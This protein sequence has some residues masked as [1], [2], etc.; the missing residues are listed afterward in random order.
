MSVCAV[1]PLYARPAE[2]TIYELCYGSATI[3][4]CAYRNIHIRKPE[5]H[6]C[7]ASDILH[8]L[9]RIDLVRSSE[10]R[11]QC[12]TLTISV[13][14]NPVWRSTLQRRHAKSGGYK[15]FWEATD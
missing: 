1:E 9:R 15:C 11:R 13:L 6:R 12:L 7:R 2:R 8:A 4:A 10:G 14:V 3:S 5:Q